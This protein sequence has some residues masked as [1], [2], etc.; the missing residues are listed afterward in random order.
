MTRFAVIFFATLIILTFFSNTI[1]NYS[2]PEV[3]TETVYGSSVSQKV[4]CQGSVEVSSDLEVTV[5]GQ[6]V[7]KEVFFEDGDEVKEGDVIMTFEETENT[8]LAEAQK[9]LESLQLAYEKQILR[10]STDYT[11]DEVAIQNA[12]DDVAEAQSN[13]EQAKTDEANLATAKAERDAAQSAYDEKNV[14]VQ[15]LQAEVDAYTT[16]SENGVASATDALVDKLGTAKAELTTIETTLNSKKDLVEELSAKTSVE[17]AEDTLKSKQQNLDSLV[18]GLASKK[19]TDS[20]TAQTNALSDQESLEQ[21][22]EQKAK[23]EKLKENDDY[24]EIKAGGSGI[25]SGITAKK[26]DKVTA[27]SPVASIQLAENGYEVSCTISK[28]Q[29]QL[30]RIGDEASIENIWGDDVS[31]TVKSIKADPTNPN[32]SSIVKFKVQGNVQ[33]GETLQ[34]AVGEKS[35]KYDTVVP[36]SAVKE[37]S[38]GKFVYVV[39]IKATPLGNRYIVKKV[40]VEV[41]ASDTSSSA[42]QG[43][44][45]QYDNVIT[46]ASKPLDNGQ[47]VRLSDN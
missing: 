38:D 35:G 31:S 39:K 6:R 5:S 26:G 2:L 36:N 14:E 45:S 40:K 24:S 3:S 22:E 17:D 15:A 43:E 42:I 34:F 1:M 29:S 46:N 41:L 4:R 47:Q 19:E 10:T 8:E 7:V 9:T 25:I 18:R 37:D 11:D 20:I 21:I 16:L 12:R 44:V 13:L 28:Q 23:I 27:D 30:L 33:V 32:Q